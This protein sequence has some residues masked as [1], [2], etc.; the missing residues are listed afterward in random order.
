[1]TKLGWTVLAIIVLAGLAFG[2]MLSFGPG[3]GS[4]PKTR[5]E[6]PVA[7]E[8]GLTIPVAGVASA[9]LTDTWG[10]SRGAGTRVHKAI[11]IA[12][13]GGTPVLA[14][15][16]GRIEKLFTSA[17]GGITLYVRSPDRGWSY[18]YAHL[19]RY[20][21]DVR[22]GGEV[23]AGQVIGYVGDTGNSGAGNYHLHFGLSRMRADD[24]W[25]EGEPVNPYPLLAG[26]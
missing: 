7:R 1:M 13:P 23:R 9:E 5:S 8:A 22:E 15:A 6:P 24:G 10:D 20:A 14:A 25:W 21:P 26:R 16:P 4:L 17:D 11:D 19:A 12:A 3:N 2:S 18:Y